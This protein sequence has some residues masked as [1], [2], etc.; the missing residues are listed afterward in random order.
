MHGILGLSRLEPRRKIVHYWLVAEIECETR[1]IKPETKKN[2][3]PVVSE[4]NMDEKTNSI[5]G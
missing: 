3:L 4:L 1:Q 5:V 2:A